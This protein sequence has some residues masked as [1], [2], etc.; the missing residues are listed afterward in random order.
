MGIF[1]K[2]FLF[3]TQKLES[4]EHRQDFRFTPNQQYPLKISLLHKNRR[5]EVKLVNLSKSGLKITA[6]NFNID[7]ILEKNIELKLSLINDQ[8]RISAKIIYKNKNFLGL[9]IH[10]EPIGPLLDYYQL[11][12][13]ILIARSMSEKDNANSKIIE[14]QG[15]ESS[16][17]LFKKDLKGNILQAQISLEKDQLNIII[18]KNLQFF[19]KGET[20]LALKH[21]DERYQIYFQFYKWF[22]LHLEDDFPKELLNFLKNVST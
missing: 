21:N 11:I 2:I 9:K 8:T 7:E 17:M 16:F 5:F 1:S 6:P 19:I 15:I 20:K 18:D 14:Y 3:D 13:P 12:Y 10:N 4:L 22:L